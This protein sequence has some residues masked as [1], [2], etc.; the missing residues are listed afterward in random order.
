MY[1]VLCIVMYFSFTYITYYVITVFAIIVY[2]C[3]TAWSRV[4]VG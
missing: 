4:Y 1:Y 3:S 2:I